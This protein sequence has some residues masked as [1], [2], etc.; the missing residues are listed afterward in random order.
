MRQSGAVG[1]GAGHPR[2]REDAKAHLEGHV[3]GAKI[4]KSVEP[5]D[6]DVFH[7]FLFGGQVYGAKLPIDEDVV[8][9]VFWLS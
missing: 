2:G 5:I 9:W 6:E 3:V 8:H 1:S 7:W 4:A